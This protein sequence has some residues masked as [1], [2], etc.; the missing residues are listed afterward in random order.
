MKIL[1]IETTDDGT[2]TSAPTDIE[3]IAQAELPTKYGAFVILTWTKE[4][5]AEPVA[6]VTKGFDPS[7]PVLVRIH[8]ECLTGDVFGS[9]RC[10]CGEQASKALEKIADSKNGVF[11]YDRNEGRGIGLYEKIRAY[12]VQQT[13]Q[14]DTYAANHRLGFDTDLRDYAEAVHILQTLDVTTCTLLTDNPD[15]LHAVQRAGICVTQET[16]AV[17]ANE[18]NSDYIAT[19]QEW[20][21]KRSG[22]LES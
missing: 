3:G 20:Q 22:L 21:K 16:L 1:A 14:L 2:A 15:K 9:L 6:L 12:A 18:H 8:S 4:K 7:K 17:Q 11:I 10:D 19:K 13:E 5:G